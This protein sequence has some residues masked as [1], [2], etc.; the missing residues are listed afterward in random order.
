MSE[1]TSPQKKHK[2][3]LIGSSSVGK[4]SIVIRFANKTFPTSQESTIGAAFISRDV[5]T[6][7]GN[8]VSLHVWD[9]AGQERYRSLVPRYSQG[10]SAIIIVYDVTDPD[11]FE[12]AK[13]WHRETREIQHEDVIWFLV[14][15][16]CDLNATVDREKAKEFAEENGLTYF[17]TSAKTGQGVEELFIQIASMLKTFP[18][19]DA[20]DLDGQDAD[21]KPCC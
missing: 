1:A 5:Q 7:K 8:I 13:E 9:T 11:S 3:V 4:T 18:S 20:V 16:K 10:A 21:K 14:G 12:E 17:E 2:V 6:Q 15:N 19:N